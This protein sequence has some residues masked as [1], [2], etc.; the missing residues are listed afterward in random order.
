MQRIIIL[1]I[2]VTKKK[3]LFYRGIEP[4][5]PGLLVLNTTT[6]PAGLLAE[7]ALKLKTNFSYNV[8]RTF[9]IG[10]KVVNSLAF[11]VYTPKLLQISIMIFGSLTI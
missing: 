2:G 9:T 11:P 6:R 10:K 1:C 5:N 4:G 7:I 8:N 3:K